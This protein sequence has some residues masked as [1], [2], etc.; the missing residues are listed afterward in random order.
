MTIF[1]SAI[2]TIGS[3]RMNSRNSVKK[4]PKLPS[5]VRISTHVGQYMPQAAGRKSAESDVTMS[6]KRSNHMPTLTRNEITS[7]AGTLVRT[8]LN[9]KSWGQ[10]TL[11][12]TI[13]QYAQ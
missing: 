8:R 5:S 1:T 2:A 10:M 3:Q 12:E 9:Q 7:I 4:S 11:H 6:V 13:S